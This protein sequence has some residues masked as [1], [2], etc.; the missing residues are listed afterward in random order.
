MFIPEI[1][2]G[3]T[4][5][6]YL[7]GLYSNHLSR[8]ISTHQRL[9]LSHHFNYYT[10]VFPTTR[11]RK[12]LADLKVMRNDAIIARD[13]SKGQLETEEKKVYGERKERE[14]KLAKVKKEA[15]EKK[16]L[17]EQRERRMVCVSLANIRCDD[18]ALCILV[19]SMLVNLRFVWLFLG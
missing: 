5:R 12:E 6:L 16:Q 11:C 9:T 10:F 15:E 17:Q 2:R 1:I 14:N 13:A 7:I 18:D 3:K 19:N 8:H 4:M